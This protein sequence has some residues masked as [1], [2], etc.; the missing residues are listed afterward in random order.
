MMDL[1]RLH[2]A[3]SQER[4]RLWKAHN[5]DCLCLVCSHRCVPGLLCLVPSLWWPQHLKILRGGRAT[6]SGLVGF[7]VDHVGSLTTPCPTPIA[8]SVSLVVSLCRGEGLSP[9]AQAVSGLLISGLCFLSAQI[10]VCAVL[11]LQTVLRQPWLP[12]SPSPGLPVFII[13]IPALQSAFSLKGE[14]Y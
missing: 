4:P 11:A 3:W 7:P 13:K 1:T 6:S 12:S 9:S 14:L 2:L 8:V 10:G 5:I